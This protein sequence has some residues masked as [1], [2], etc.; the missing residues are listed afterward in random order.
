ML[1]TLII[2]SGES[3]M[4][5]TNSSNFFLPPLFRSTLLRHRRIRLYTKLGKSE[6]QKREREGEGRHTCNPAWNTKPWQP[7]APRDDSSFSCFLM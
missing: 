7:K 4:S 1:R 3:R 6:V 5:L 2:A